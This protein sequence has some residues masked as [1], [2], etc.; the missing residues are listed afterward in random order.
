MRTVS[1][2]E[3][4]FATPWATIA[5]PRH[6]RRRYAIPYSKPAGHIVEN[7]PDTA[8]KAQAERSKAIQ[9]VLRGSTVTNDLLVRRRR[10]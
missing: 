4:R 1:A 5:S 2:T 8:A 6:P 10:R 7:E 9:A 3:S